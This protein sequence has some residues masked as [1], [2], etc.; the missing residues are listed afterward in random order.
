MVTKPGGPG[1]SNKR[2][3]GPEDDALI[4]AEIVLKKKSSSAPGTEMRH[5]LARL[6]TVP[7]ADILK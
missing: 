4:E 3:I 7:R 1:R 5:A 2:K 6:T